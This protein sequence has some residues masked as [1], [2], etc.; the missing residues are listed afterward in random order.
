MSLPDPVAALAALR[1]RVVEHPWQ[2]VGGAF[3]LGAHAASLQPRLPRNRIARA[4]LAMVGGIALR[5]SRV[6]ATSALL[7]GAREWIWP[8]PE[9][10]T[11]SRS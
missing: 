7:G 1:A 6:A 10:T 3:L 5:A 2:A 8:S 11:R 9:P 4:V